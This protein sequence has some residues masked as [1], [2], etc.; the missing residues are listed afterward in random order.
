[1]GASSINEGISLSDLK[2]VD[3]STFFHALEK[4]KGKNPQ[5][6][7]VTLHNIKDYDSCK[8]VFLLYDNSAGV[9]VEEDG[10]IIS[11]FSDRTHKGV[12]KYLIAKA[13]EVGGNKLD[14]FGSEGLRNLYLSRG[15]IPI[16]RTKFNCNFAPEDW[17]YFRD[18]EPDIIFWVYDRSRK[19]P[20]VDFV[21]VV[22]W[23][24]IPEFP[25]YEEAEDYRNKIQYKKY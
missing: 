2:E 18:G 19:D 17:N 8:S 25:S 12:L 7:Y 22:D 14:C 20:F 10:N 15:F 13:L 9:A 3:S 5:G 24:N 1:M 4:A 11:V 16:S 6:A 21:L 23:K